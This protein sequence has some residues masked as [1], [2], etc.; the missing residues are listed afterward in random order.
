MI[1]VTESDA[2][3]IKLQKKKKNTTQ[4]LPQSKIKARKGVSL[5]A[6]LHV[7]IHSG[8]SL[9]SNLRSACETWFLFIIEG[10]DFEQWNY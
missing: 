8:G 7:S 6:L 2:T 10:T 5:K 4:V 9:H 3:Q 1:S